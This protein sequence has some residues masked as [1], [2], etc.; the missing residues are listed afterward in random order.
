MGY[1]RKP[2]FKR[3]AQAVGAVTSSTLAQLFAYSNYNYRWFSLDL[4]ARILTYY[5]SKSAT[6]SRGEIDM[7]TIMKV[8]RS[9]LFD[10]PEHSIDLV[11]ATRRY[12]LTAESEAVIVRWAFVFHELIRR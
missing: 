2:D 3:D 4:S 10:A 12:T 6:T 7:N 8:Q 11:S 5:K 9:T 1:L